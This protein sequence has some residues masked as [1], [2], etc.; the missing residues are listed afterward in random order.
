MREPNDGGIDILKGSMNILGSTARTIISSLVGLL[1]FANG[2]VLTVNDRG[3]KRSGVAGT[4]SMG[5]RVS[6]I[7]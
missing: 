3:R 5:V 7:L 2:A 4:T 1:K 6:R